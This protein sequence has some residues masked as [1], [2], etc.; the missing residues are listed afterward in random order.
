MTEPPSWPAP[1]GGESSPIPP[2]PTAPPQY[3]APQYGAPQYGVPGYGSAGYPP[4]YGGYQQPYG[5]YQQ[6]YAVAAPKP[7]IIP[8]RPLAVGEIL[9]GAFATIRRHPR[10]TLG[11]SAAVACIQQGL[12]LAVQLSAGGLTRTSGFGTDNSPSDGAIASFVAGIFG[13]VLISAVLSAV[14]TGALCLI[15]SDSILGHE[16]S[17]SAAWRRLRPQAW[18]L[19]AVSFLVAIGQTLGLVL[20]I[21]PGVFLWGAWALAIPAL[22]LEKTTVWGAMRRSWRLATPS[23]WRVFGIRLLGTV[24][25]SAL[26]GALT[27]VAG[28]SAFTAALNGDTATQAST[29][30][31]I[32]AAVLG[33]LAATLTAPFLAGM[34]TLLYV[35]RRIRAEALDVQLQRAAAAP[36]GIHGASTSFG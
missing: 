11:L 24:V 25:A 7:G 2:P 18:R 32:L 4:P 22:V 29:F 21:L 31:V 36:A 26:K 30:S 12:L 17:A 13:T 5:G 35:D 14:L 9:D 3:G 16:T 34:V 23:W 6:P 28:A 27:A 8:L 1:S 20:C 33:V 15:V 19:L 10:A